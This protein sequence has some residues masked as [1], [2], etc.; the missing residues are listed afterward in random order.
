MTS[1]ASTPSALQGDCPRSLLCPI[2]AAR[3]QGYQGEAL[4]LTLDATSHPEEGSADA[5]HSRTRTLRWGRPS[6]SGVV[7]SV[8]QEHSLL[9]WCPPPPPPS[10]VRAH[11]LGWGCSRMNSG[12][13]SPRNCRQTT[14]CICVYLNGSTRRA[15][16]KKHVEAALHA[17]G[18]TRPAPVCRTSQQLS[19][20]PRWENWGSGRGRHSPKVTQ[21]LEG[22]AERASRS[23]DSKLSV[24]RPYSTSFIHSF[25][26]TSLDCVP[27][28]VCVCVF[29]NNY[30]FIWLLWAFAVALELLI[31]ACKI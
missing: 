16:V 4:Q 17:L 11:L 28:C 31:V 1:G 25:I 2:W 22:E 24:P 26:H 29:S 18:H 20:R 30:S 7:R 21:L 19:E 6:L 10:R 13:Q 27:G 5:T 3:P 23:A 9:T 8:H 14:T 15:K 12:S